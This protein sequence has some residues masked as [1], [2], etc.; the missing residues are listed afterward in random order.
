M[1]IQAARAPP[2]ARSEDVGSVFPKV[3]PEALRIPSS[4]LSTPMTG[5]MKPPTPPHPGQWRALAQRRLCVNLTCHGDLPCGLGKGWAKASP[6]HRRSYFFNGILIKPFCK[7][8]LPP[9]LR[10]SPRG[11]VCVGAQW[12]PDL[13]SSSLMTPP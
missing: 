9:S 3:Q 6:I 5:R 7:K 13:F 2:C 4:P 10:L 1:S 8:Y 12:G 11:G